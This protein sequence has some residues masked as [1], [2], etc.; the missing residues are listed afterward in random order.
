MVSHRLGLITTIAVV[1][2]EL[3]HEIGDL[4]VLIDS[5]LSMCRALVLNLLSA[6]TAYI[7]LFIAL[8]LGK[9]E[10]AETIL[11]AITAGMFLYVA[12]VDM[13]GF[14]LIVTFLEIDQ[15]Y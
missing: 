12:W 15:T 11:L 2:H 1:C 7:G 5:G 3:P 14:Q 13:V 6:L 8:G 4:A 9:N 10:T